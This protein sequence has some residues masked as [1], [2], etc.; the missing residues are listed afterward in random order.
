M[1][2]RRR[3]LE[4]WDVWIAS[5]VIAALNAP[6]IL[7]GHANVALV[8]FPDAVRA[9]EWWRLVLHPF[10]HVSLWHL[11]LDG[12]AFVLLLR[13]LDTITPIRRLAIAGVAAATSATAASL[14]AGELAAHGLCGLSGAAH[15]LMA[16]SGLVMC[17]QGDGSDRRLGRWLLGLVSAKAIFEAASGHIL[18]EPVYHG[19]LGLPNAF[20]HLGGVLGGVLSALVIGMRSGERRRGGPCVRPGQLKDPLAGE[21]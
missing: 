4:T 17:C 1:A 6:L 21:S 2:I 8:F 15:G 20:C 12:L 7:S 9:G 3:L 18:F 14:R 10:V 16:A 13:S 11:A 5:A 19:Q